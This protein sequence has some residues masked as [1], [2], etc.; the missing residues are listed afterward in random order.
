MRQAANGIRQFQIACVFEIDHVKATIPKGIATMVIG[1]LSGA[2][3]VGAALKFKFSGRGRSWTVA[4]PLA[5]ERVNQAAPVVYGVKAHAAMAIWWEDTIDGAKYDKKRHQLIFSYRPPLVRPF[6]VY[7][8]AWARRIFVGW[9]NGHGHRLHLSALGRMSPEKRCRSSEASAIRLVVGGPRF[10]YRVRSAAWIDRK[11]RFFDRVMAYAGAL[12]W[13]N[14]EL[15]ARASRGCRRLSDERLLAA[16]YGL[17]CN[18]FGKTQSM[19]AVRVLAAAGFASTYGPPFGNMM[20]LNAPGRRL[21]FCE[22]NAE[23][24]LGPAPFFLFGR[25]RGLQEWGIVA[26]AR[27]AWKYRGI[28]LAAGLCGLL[29]PDASDGLIGVLGG[30]GIGSV[31]TGAHR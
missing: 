22:P 30:N 14:V 24:W 8:P 31:H 2:L 5:L 18:G 28:G 19:A 7:M 21:F 26:V 4:A 11:K 25:N 13:T 6:V 3:P 16:V 23:S 27:P 29:G 15:F 9:E 20:E 12:P 10:L 17:E 1:G